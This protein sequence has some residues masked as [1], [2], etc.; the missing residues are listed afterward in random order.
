MSRVG[1]KPILIPDGVKA[2][3]KQGELFV[4]GG[5]GNLSYRFHPC[6]KVEIK[7]K[8][9][10]VTCQSE[11]NFD[12]SLHGSTRSIMDNMIKGITQGFSKEL[13]IIGVGLR[14]QLQ[15]NILI[16][17]LGFSHTIDFP[18]PAGISIEVP[19]PNQIKVSGIDKYKVG[20]AAAKIRS[21]YPPEPYKGK[22]IRYNN[23]Y[24]RRKAGKTVA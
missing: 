4:E 1:K 14:A 17:R 6:L 12:R 11:S 13:E 23:E 8:E 20:E 5:K 24:V 21:F 19:K 9:I 10:I 2:E 7:E 22:G 15:N 16:L 18:V 3:I